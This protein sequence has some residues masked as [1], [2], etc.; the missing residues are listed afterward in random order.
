ML[1]GDGVHLGIAVIRLIVN[2]HVVTHSEVVVVAAGIVHRGNANAVNKGARR[3]AGVHGDVVAIQIAGGAVSG[4]SGI[5][6]GVTGGHSHHGIRAYEAVQQ[7][8]VSGVPGEAGVRGTQRQVHG[9]AA[10]DDGVFDGGHVVGVISAAAHAEDLH[11][12]DLRI[13]GNTLH[14]HGLQRVGEGSVAVGDEAVGRRNTLDVGAMLALRVGVMID[15]TVGL[16]DVVVA[17]R[18]LGGPVQVLRS[19]AGS[20][21]LCVQLIQNLRDIFGVHQ[22]NRAVQLGQRVIER[23]SV[24]ALVIQIQT[25]IHNSDLGAGAGVARSPGHVGA[26]HQTRGSGVGI[27]SLIPLHNTGLILG[28][29]KDVLDAGHRRDGLHIAIGDVGG[30]DVGSQGQVPLDVQLGADGSLDLR[31]HGFLL[32][33]E[34]VSVGHCVVVLRNI[35]GGEA[36]LNGRLLF[37]DDG[38]THDLIRR[39]YRFI[40]HLLWRIVDTLSG[41]AFHFLEAETGLIR[42]LGACGDDQTENQ[43]QNQKAGKDAGTDAFLHGISSP[44]KMYYRLVGRRPL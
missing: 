34:F 42:G 9:S 17:V 33:L 24:E 40:G 6:T 27:G 39:I 43:R 3:A 41:D 5:V 25:G 15:D 19:Q 4:G 18:H 13:R 7:I 11:N 14:A 26:D 32:G 2:D 8:L 16:V 44:Y 30:D 36:S 21:V 20:S 23:G 31:G 10:Q 37:H 1:A 28:F 12:N 35:R 29:H 22:I 38:Y